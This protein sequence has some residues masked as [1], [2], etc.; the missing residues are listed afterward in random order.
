MVHVFIHRS[1]EMSLE[2]MLSNLSQLF[3]DLKNVSNFDALNTEKIWFPIP[4]FFLKRSLNQPI[5]QWVF[6]Q[7]LS[8]V[9][10]I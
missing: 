10:V 1:E 8:F 6:S 7:K 5:F 9:R 3:R 4:N 2:N